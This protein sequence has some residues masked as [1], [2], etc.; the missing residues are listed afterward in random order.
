MT[1]YQLSTG[2]TILIDILSIALQTDEEYERTMETYIAEDI[3]FEINNPFFLGNTD[4]TIFLEI[5]E[6]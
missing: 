5:E 6:P 3:G 4:E 1:Y 2:K